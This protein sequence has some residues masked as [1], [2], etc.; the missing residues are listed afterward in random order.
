MLFEVSLLVCYGYAQLLI[1]TCSIDEEYNK[2]VKI[3][4]YNV[5][6]EVSIIQFLILVCRRLIVIRWYYL[7]EGDTTCTQFD[8]ENI[9]LK[10]NTEYDSNSDREILDEATSSTQSINTTVKQYF[11]VSVI[12]C[13]VKILIQVCIFSSI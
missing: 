13:L 7:Q 5:E 3:V 12:N 1:I 8:E 6:T 4:Y 11:E 2:I 10:L 9:N